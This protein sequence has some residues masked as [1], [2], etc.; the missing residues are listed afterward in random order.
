MGIPFLHSTFMTMNLGL[1]HFLQFLDLSSTVVSRPILHRP[2][3]SPSLGIHGAG[4]TSFPDC[5]HMPMSSARLCNPPCS[6]LIPPA[7]TLK[8]IRR[9]SLKTTLLT[10]SWLSH[11]MQIRTL[12]FLPTGDLAQYLLRPIYPPTHTPSVHL[13]F[14]APCLL[15]RPQVRLTPHPHRPVRRFYNPFQTSHGPRGMLHKT[16]YPILSLNQSFL[17]CRIRSEAW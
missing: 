3:I 1:S 10:T 16:F 5:D 15:H 6:S 7:P 14:T 13:S 4:K 11:R 17:I 2:L 12:P 8:P 9:R